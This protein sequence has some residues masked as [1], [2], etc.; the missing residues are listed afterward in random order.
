MPTDPHPAPDSGERQ[1]SRPTARPAVE[2]RS[3]SYRYASTDRAALEDVSVLVEPREFL[4][5]IGP[6][7][8]GKSTFLRL[9]LGLIQP[10]RG[11]IDVL[12]AAPG[13]HRTQVGYV[14]QQAAID[15]SA[16]ATVLD[17]VLLGRLHRKVWGPRWSAGD[18]AAAEQALERVGL[19]EL[20]GR[21]W[22]EL[23][24]GQRQRTLIARALVGGPELLLLDEPTTGVDVH[25]EHALVDLLHELNASMAILMVSHDLSL[26]ASHVKAALWVNRRAV[27]LPAQELTVE[28]VESL[29]HGSDGSHHP[30]QSA[31]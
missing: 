8:G 30:E 17:I 7:G 26:V 31:S 11:T 16:P 29:L 25:R 27:Q 10:Q 3:V 1:V 15:D 6:N 2:F 12:G 5:I 23:S 4:G 24:G 14:P 21:S 28:R 18:H 22:A 9:I 13:S 20:S 19:T